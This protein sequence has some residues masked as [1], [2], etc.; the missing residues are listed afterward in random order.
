MK[1]KQKEKKVK[2]IKKLYKDSKQQKKN[3]KTLN[4]MLTNKRIKQIL[5]SRFLN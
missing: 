5:L 2:T 1:T 4:K 3:T